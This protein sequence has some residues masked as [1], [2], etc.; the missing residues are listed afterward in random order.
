VNISVLPAIKT[1]SVR[2]VLFSISVLTKILYRTLRIKSDCCTYKT[3][4][5]KDSCVL[6]AWHNR[7]SILPFIVN[8]LRKAT[9]TGLVSK[10]RDGD[11]L[12][13][14]LAHF[15]V[16]SERGSSSSNGARSAINLI[17]VL[18]A[19]G[20]V[21]ITPDGPRGPKYKAKEGLLSIC[22]KS[23]KTRMIFLQINFH[24]TW[25]FRSWDGFNIPK[26]FSKVDIKAIE[27]KNVDMLK[28]SAKSVNMSAIEY[29]ETILG[30]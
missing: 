26:P 23:L 4:A 25:K 27:Y 16:A 9:I 22:E 1:V 15:G 6:I 17:K 7:I 5:N 20:S 2:F 3:L 21:C 29:C 11:F 14:F 12:E 13:M 28:E 8:H 10:S 24:N 19:G 18:R 30:N